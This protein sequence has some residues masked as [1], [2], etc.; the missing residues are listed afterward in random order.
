MVYIFYNKNYLLCDGRP[1]V[2]GWSSYKLLSLITFIELNALGDLYVSYFP[3]PSL[4]AF[5]AEFDCL[6]FEF[7]SLKSLF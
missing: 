2:G 4:N 5:R 7:V 6:S 3:K 1:N